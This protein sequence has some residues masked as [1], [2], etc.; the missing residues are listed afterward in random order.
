M[1]NNMQCGKKQFTNKALRLAVDLRTELNVPS[2]LVFLVGGLLIGVPEGVWLGDGLTCV[3]V[4]GL[5]VL[6]VPLPFFCHVL[7]QVVF[8]IVALACIFVPVTG[9]SFVLAFM[10][11]HSQSTL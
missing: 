11:T 5:R 3:S 10:A 6:G 4:P 9:Q 7:G 1:Y 2:L 8:C